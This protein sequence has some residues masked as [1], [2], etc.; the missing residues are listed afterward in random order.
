MPAGDPVRWG[1]LGPGLVA[2]AA[3]LPAIGR[4]VGGRVVAVGSRDR[5]RAIRAAAIHGPEA[6]AYEGYQAVL[7][8]PRVE[9]VYIALP[10]HLHLPWT[11]AAARA[12][13]H[14][15]CEK[16]LA[17]NAAE[18]DEMIAACESAGVLLAE[19]IMY[20]YH[21]RMVRLH[22]LVASGGIGTVRH[23]G[24]AFSFTMAESAN[25]RA[26]V[27]FGGGALL[28]VGSYGVSAARWLAGAEPTRVLAVSRN[29]PETGIDL[30]LDALL[31]FPTGATAHVFCGFTAAEH[32]GITVVGSEAVVEVP[33]A[34]TAWRDDPALIAVRR[35]P[36]LETIELAPAD[37]YFEMVEHFQTAVRGRESLRF[38]PE[39]GLANLRVLEAV[40]TSAA[41]GSAVVVGSEW[42]SPPRPRP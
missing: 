1:I 41:T 21:P 24:A 42:T 39:D 17:L 38:A 7:D 14:V 22:Q 27:E 30:Q 31:D 18:A 29:H 28:D 10:N 40:R 16:P 26:Q 9:A 11:V 6:R 37:P 20:R 2:T 8:D 35:R 32:Q 12:G 4:S 3:V 19:A 5:A 25:Y 15:L 23:I 34:F 33:L 36:D 13:K